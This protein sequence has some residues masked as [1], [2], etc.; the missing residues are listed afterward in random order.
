MLTAAFDDWRAPD[1]P[2]RTASALADAAPI[3]KL[4]PDPRPASLQ[5]MTATLH[6][7][8]ESK[9]GSSDSAATTAP[10]GPTRGGR[11]VAPASAAAIPD[12]SAVALASALVPTPQ[13]PS[14]LPV[15]HSAETPP[16]DPLTRQIDA[17]D[18]ALSTDDPGLRAVAL[19]AFGQTWPDSGLAADAALAQAEAWLAASRPEEVESAVASLF[20]V[21]QPR[22]L[23]QKALILRARAL[24][25][26][27]RC[28]DLRALRRSESERSLRH[29]LK[30]QEATCRARRSFR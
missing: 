10:P 8:P 2:L 13:A 9:E 19:R 14:Q 18:A 1:A 30:E 26:Q 16:A 17:F 24:T 28:A 20:Q 11:I 15:P 6:P 3:G 27:G 7:L 21:N 22:L 23:T 12:L 5:P 4:S 29:T 25:E